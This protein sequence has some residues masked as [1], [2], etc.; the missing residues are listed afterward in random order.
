VATFKKHPDRPQLKAEFSAWNLAAK[1][2]E[3]DFNFVPPKGAMKIEMRKQEK[4]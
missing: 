4:N 1:T 3:R 2:S